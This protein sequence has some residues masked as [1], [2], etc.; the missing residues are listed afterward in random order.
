MK[1]SQTL[2]AIRRQAEEWAAIDPTVH[3]SPFF[4]DAP[5]TR[6]RT[7]ASARQRDGMVILALLNGLDTAR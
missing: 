6:V 1:D 4:Q 7:V 5:S 2:A 3:G